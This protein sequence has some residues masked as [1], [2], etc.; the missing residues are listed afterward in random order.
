MP[1]GA[2]NIRSLS[3]YVAQTSFQC[4][5]C[6]QRTRVLALAL[7][8]NHEMLTE[9]EWRTVDASAFL[10]YV[11]ELPQAVRRW[12]LQLSPL[13]RLAM[14]TDAAGPYWANHCEHC[15]RIVSDDELHCEPG[16]FMPSTADQAETIQLSST[17][18][19]FSAV[20]AGHAPEP[21]FFMSMRRR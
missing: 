18:Q 8:P 5:H 4:R 11:T 14:C 16:G 20:V 3:Y 2:A 7:P 21:E 10:F 12:L 9:D 1:P 6:A 13:F 15:G 17:P 19:A